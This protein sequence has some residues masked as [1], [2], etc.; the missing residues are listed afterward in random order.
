MFWNDGENTSFVGKYNFNNDKGT[1]E[2]FGFEEGDE[3]WE[4]KNNTS[5][6]VLWKSADFD[7]LWKM[8]GQTI[9]ICMLLWWIAGHFLSR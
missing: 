2:V 9:M 8:P 5:N 4:I 6:R 3:S 1:E 7:R